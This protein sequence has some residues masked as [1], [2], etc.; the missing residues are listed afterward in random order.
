MTVL[1]RCGLSDE[2]ICEV[3]GVSDPPDDVS[4]AAVVERGYDEEFTP[5]NLYDQT[6]RVLAASSRGIDAPREYPDRVVPQQ[7]E[8][9]FD[10]YG[11]HVHFLDGAGNRIDSG[12]T[13]TQP[14]QIALE[15]PN[16][17]VRTTTFT[18]PDT[19]LG[20]NNYPALIAAV[21]DG[22]LDGVPLTFAML[23]NWAD[24]RW[25]FVLFESRRLEALESHYGDGIEAFGEAL[26]HEHRPAEFAATIA[27]S[28]T[29]GGTDE[30]V[31]AAEAG[32]AATADESSGDIGVDES[33]EGW[34]G[35]GM[36]DLSDVDLDGEDEATAAEPEAADAADADSALDSIFSEM[37][38]A[39]DPSGETGVEVQSTG[40][41]VRDLLSETGSAAS[42]R[43]VESEPEP[44]AASTSDPDT[45][46]EP[47]GTG[48][49][50]IDTQ[51]GPV[52]EQDPDSAPEPDPEPAT[53][54]EP[55]TDESE[56][57]SGFVMADPEPVEDDPDLQPGSP[58]SGEPEPA[59][60]PVEMDSPAEE[61]PE[62]G[63]SEASA[64]SETESTPEREPMPEPASESEPEPAPESTSEPE[65][66]TAVEP[67]PAPAAD[68]APAQESEPE[69]AQESSTEPEPTR[70]SEPTREPEPVTFGSDTDEPESAG[71]TSNDSEPAAGDSSTTASAESSESKGLVGRIVGAIKGLF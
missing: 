31:T 17:N 1:K 38:A 11:F 5:R 55:E 46:S 4:V 53:T 61:A 16:G 18:Y 26:L 63:S 65:P 44:A 13:P 45:A 39:A 24:D 3:Y 19:P 43:P 37:E 22:L 51:P 40:K 33:T 23:S 2:E 71:A 58:D 52:S 14:F 60:E 6:H 42:E 34:L 68:S 9:V 48:S 30:Q 62:P 8:T 21:E 7:L 54:P 69:P 66:T 36:A 47:A 29:T 50:D 10:A 41:S 49:A 35:D 28:G 32:G 56:A 59:A 57:E 25:R 70:E 12:A 64:I 27:N 67:E 20:T 15:D